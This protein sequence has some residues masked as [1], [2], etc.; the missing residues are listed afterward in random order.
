MDCF[1]STS[2]K[3][4]ILLQ[5]T[6]SFFYSLIVF[7][8]NKDSVIVINGDTI[9]K[10][11]IKVEKE[12]EFKGGSQAWLKFLNK[13]IRYPEAAIDNNVRGTAIIEFMIDTVGAIS[14]IKIIEDPGSGLG[15]EAA[16]IIKIS[17]GQWEPAMQAGRKIKALK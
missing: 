1:K 12:A 4:K 7:S 16:R 9:V 14:E 2:V 15:A 10:T 6:V 5:L 3:Y 11:F 8:Q 17:K 13:N